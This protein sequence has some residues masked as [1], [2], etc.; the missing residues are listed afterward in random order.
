MKVINHRLQESCMFH[1]QVP[2]M[3]GIFCGTVAYLTIFRVDENL[4]RQLVDIERKS[5]TKY[6]LDPL[7]SEKSENNRNSIVKV[8]EVDDLKSLDHSKRSSDEKKEKIDKP[9]K[10]I[11]PKIDKSQTSI[12]SKI[13]KSI[14]KS[15]NNNTQCEKMRV[16]FKDEFP[17]VVEFPMAD[18]CSRWYRFA[19]EIRSC[20]SDFLM[21]TPDRRLD[22]W[23]RLRHATEC[24]SRGIFE[25][26]SVTP[27]S[28]GT[29]T[30]FVVF[31]T[32]PTLPCYALSIGL[33]KDLSTTRKLHEVLPQCEQYAAEADRNV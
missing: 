29:D 6:I 11:D 4:P 2:L 30:K 7:I 24:C 8:V 22:A 18:D 3:L 14:F 10:S 26:L 27:L 25:M 15:E 33:S 5:R 20:T 19:D 32:S 9:E 12:N 13:D 17:A 16:R 23:K 28:K 21:K 31:P 1:V